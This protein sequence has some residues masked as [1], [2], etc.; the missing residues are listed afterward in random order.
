MWQLALLT[1]RLQFMCV[2]LKNSHSLRVSVREREEEGVGDAKV[3]TKPSSLIV[4]GI[5]FW[6]HLVAVGRISLWRLLLA[7]TRFM[8]PLAKNN[9]SN[10]NNNKL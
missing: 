6:R 4:S 5:V 8:L 1:W 7:K 10:N 2:P 3:K 9:T